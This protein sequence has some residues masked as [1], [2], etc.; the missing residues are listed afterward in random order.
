MK[1]S[2]I[3]IKNLNIE[4][5]SENQKVVALEKINLDINKNEFICIMG[6]SGCGKTTLLN[7]LAG[8]IQPTN[9]KILLKG[10]EI[11]GPGPD[12]AVVFQDDAVFPWL[13]V[14]DNIAYSHKIKSTYGDKE[15][16]L[17]KNYINLVG[18]EDFKKAWPRQLSGGMRKRVDLAR[19]FSAEPELLLMDEPFGALD[20]MTKEK[21]QEELRKFWVE[22]PRTIVF[23]T[24]DVEEAVF[25]GDKVIVMTPR[26][27]RIDLIIEPNLSKNRDMSIKS[28]SVFF[29]NVKKIRQRIKDH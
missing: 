6:V 7:A 13:S 29:D 26:P 25:L 20:I 14:E 3:E 24:H 17:V 11:Q 18:L 23:I 16:E 28:D 21:L 27:G 15:K 10:N 2:I 22:R 4:F 19:A 1:D 12:R 8:F 9:G 5:T